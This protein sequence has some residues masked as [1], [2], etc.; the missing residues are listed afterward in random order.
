MVAP[1]PPGIVWP[2]RLTRRL[3]GGGVMFERFQQM[4]FLIYGC[5]LRGGHLTFVLGKMGQRARISCFGSP[6][7]PGRCPSSIGRKQI[8]GVGAGTAHSMFVERAQLKP[9]NSQ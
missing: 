6:L 5:P 9:C 2:V 7:V 4:S 8:L 3:G 1:S